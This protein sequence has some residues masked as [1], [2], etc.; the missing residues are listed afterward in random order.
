MFVASVAAGKAYCTYEAELD[1]TRPP[2]GYDSIVGEVGQ[3][4]NYDEL[5][6][7]NQAAALPQFLLVYSMPR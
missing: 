1:V 2:Q 4:L 5:V 6:V 3:H 7:Y